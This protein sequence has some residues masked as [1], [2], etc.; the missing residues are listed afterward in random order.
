MANGKG[1]GSA[2]ASHRK[3]AFKGFTAVSTSPREDIEE[4]NLT[5]RQRGRLMYMSS[6]IGAS[7]IKTHRTNTIG[8]GLRLNPRPNGKALGL[9]DEQTER[10]VEDTKEEFSIWAD[11]KRACDATGMSD[12]YEMQQLMLVSWLASGDVFALIERRKA[13]WKEPYTLRIRA[14]EADLCATK[15]ISGAWT[16]LTSGVNADNGNKIRDGVEIDAQGMPVAY[17]FRD[18]YPHESTADAT[19]WTRIRAVGEGT[20]LPNVLH[21]ANMERPGQYRGVSYMAQIIEP[22]LQIGRYTNAEI[23]AAIVQSFLTAFITTNEDASENPFNEA[24]EEGEEQAS[25][26]PSDYEMGPGQINVMNPG[27][28]VSF[29]NPTHPNSGFD[30]FVQAICTQIGA[31]LEIPRDI[32]LKEFNSSYSASRGA[33]LEAWKSF[34]MYRTWFVNDF[35][36]PVYEIWL[37]EAVASGRIKAPGFFTDRRKREAWLKAEWIGPS[38]GQLDPGKEIAAE[39]L[40][41]EYGFSTYADSAR[42]LNGSDFESNIAKLKREKERLRELETQGETEPEDPERREEQESRQTGNNRRTWAR[43]GRIRKLINMIAEKE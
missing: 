16:G 26:D 40:A 12:F 13:T 11:K 22:I 31:A 17:W 5:M 6:P 14:V 18:T 29:S 30:T 43:Q 2:G 25:Y 37:S 35:C 23:M 9:S 27:E 34:R 28:G 20:E 41:C 1:Y 24:V 4:N 33:L 3:R 21:I 36:A 10:W 8:T 39:A 38:Q 7:G 15:D 42:R 32:L 19:K